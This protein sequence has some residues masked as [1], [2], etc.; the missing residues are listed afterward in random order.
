[1]KTIH[2]SSTIKY[3]MYVRKSSEAE[4]RQALSIE[5]QVTENSKIAAQHN[6]SVSP[7]GILTESRSAKNP[8]G[9]AGFEE[10]IKRIEAGEF[11]GIVAW[12]A[13]RLSRNAIDAARL[14]H[15]MD[16]GKL[17]QII[18]Q[19]QVFKGTPQDKF[20]FNLFCSQA[21]M[22]NDNKG[23][24]VKRGQ[25][26]RREQG[27][28]PHMAK[29][30]YLNDFGKKGSCTTLE[31]KERFGLVKQAFE[32][33]LTGRYSVRSIL[34][35]VNNT[36]GLRTVQ[37][38]KEGGKPIQSSH[39]YRIL[40]DPFYA[41]FFYA[42]DENG[43]RVRYE[44]SPSVPRMIT[45]EQFWKIQAMLGRKGTPRPSLNK[46][47]FAYAGH[48]TCGTC[49]GSVTAELKHQLICS[50]CKHKF[51]YRNKE[52][53][54]QCEVSI[55]KMVNPKYLHYTYYHCIKSKNPKC[56]EGSIREEALSTHLADYLRKN[57]EIS[58]ELS[59]WCIRNLKELE[60]QEE[61]NRDDVQEAW[62]NEL[63]RKEKEE[64]NLIEMRMRSLIDDDR[65][66]ALQGPL[67]AEI[68]AIRQKVARSTPKSIRDVSRP[69]SL[70]IGLSKV[71]EGGSYREKQE[72]LAEIVSNLTLKEKKPS[73]YFKNE[74]AILMGGLKV[75]KEKNSAFEPA[76]SLADKDKTEV[77][78]SV[79]PTLLRG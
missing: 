74:F 69:F 55:A 17:V 18:T 39:M 29:I 43:N 36:L 27:F 7:E 47:T 77:F 50:S 44:V 67:K 57:L 65:F 9:R 33:Y 54:P 64:R 38:K 31:D 20:M 6:V 16:Q 66:L 23:V 13:N 34:T 8:F 76:K 3:A 53:C 14:I 49:G 24:D 40:K 5:S 48:L 72:V 15:L 19:Q 62:E 75:A 70:A 59:E 32:L 21:K 61:V 26:K 52:R 4:D 30:G 79:R 10:L 12:H 63:A 46:E 78:A 60:G 42:N 73:V 41:G 58:P 25:R 22:E 45:E 28:T 11:Q 56:P 71:F 68:E 37:R 2:K 51:A 1:M 35:H